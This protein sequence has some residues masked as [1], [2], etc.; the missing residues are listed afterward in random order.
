MKVVWDV[1]GPVTSQQIID[2]LADRMQWHPKTVRTL[3]NRLTRKGGLSFEKEGRSYLYRARVTQ[4]D[5]AR[6]AA[7]SFLD[8]VFGGSLRPML[9]QFVQEKRLSQ[10]EITELKRLLE[11]EE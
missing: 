6:A 3:I 2:A 10:R 1:A 11:E 9:A 8:R 4:E 7:Q 5:C